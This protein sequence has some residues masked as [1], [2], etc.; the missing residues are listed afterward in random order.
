MSIVITPTTSLVAAQGVSASVVLQPGTVVAAQVLQILGNDQVRIAIGGQAI[1]VQSQVPL[2]AGQTLQ[3]AVSQTT[4]GIALAVVN[5]Q[6]GAAAARVRRR[7]E[8]DRN[9]DSVTLGPG[10]TASLAAPATG[11]LARRPIR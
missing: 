10:A 11:A 4:N 6:A 5:Q 1:D 3:L 9:S 7:G 8:C 2:Q